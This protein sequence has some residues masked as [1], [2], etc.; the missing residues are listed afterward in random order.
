[1]GRI[2]GKEFSRTN[3]SGVINDRLAKQS[4]HFGKQFSQFMAK[5][6]NYSVDPF[7]P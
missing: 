6:K 2:A 5:T 7:L 1:M 3:I 4:F